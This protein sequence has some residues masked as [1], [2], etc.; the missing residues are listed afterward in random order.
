MRMNKAI[1]IIKG[2]AGFMV[3]FEH[4]KSGFLLSDH[5][6]DKHAGERLI[7]TEDEAWDLARKFADKT[8]GK[9]VNIYVTDHDFMPVDGYEEKEIKNR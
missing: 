7:E 1:S 6:P 5:F 2:D 9:C 8:K 4:V 3:N